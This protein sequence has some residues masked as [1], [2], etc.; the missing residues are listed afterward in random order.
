[1]IW[2]RT[3]QP[4]LTFAPAVASPAPI[5]MLNL[6]HETL[7]MPAFAQQL[8]LPLFADIEIVCTHMIVLFNKF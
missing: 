6:T 3:M 1:M 2:R 5:L 7:L 8:V 4:T